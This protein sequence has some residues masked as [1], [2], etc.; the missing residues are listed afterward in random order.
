MNEMQWK[1]AP[2]IFLDIRIA[3]RRALRGSL[4]CKTE[5]AEANGSPADEVVADNSARIC[6]KTVIIL[7]GNHRG[8]GAGDSPASVDS[9]Q[10]RVLDFAEQPRP[11]VGPETLGCSLG[12]A[13]DLGRLGECQ[14]SK[15]TQFD[16]LSAGGIMRGEFFQGFAD[17]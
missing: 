8:G 11:G 2:E 16:Q 4:G 1:K 15:K 5:S 12:Y 9:R 6:E 17:Q 10:S 3:G 7:T 13:H 14:T